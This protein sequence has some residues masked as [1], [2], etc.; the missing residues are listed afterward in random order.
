MIA[1]GWNC[2]GLGNPQLVR[3]LRELVQRWKPKIVFLSETKMKKY[4]MEREK[5]KIGLLNGLIV[6]SVGKSGGLA[7][8][9]SRDIKVEIQA[10]SRNHIDAVLTDP[11]SNFK[12]RITGFYGNPETHCRKE[13]WDLLRSLM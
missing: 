12:W 10:Y 5:F 13:S 11:D 4:R 8:L 9:W 6:P 1:L 2:R 7:M 3:Q